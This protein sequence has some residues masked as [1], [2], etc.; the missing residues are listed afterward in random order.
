MSKESK[1]RTP[2]SPEPAPA[3]ADEPELPAG[4]KKNRG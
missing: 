3:P 1:R 4:S 2:F